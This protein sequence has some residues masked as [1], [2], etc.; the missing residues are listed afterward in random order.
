[1][2]AACTPCRPRWQTARDGDRPRMIYS[3]T[4]LY[5]HVHSHLGGAVNE[6]LRQLFQLLSDTKTRLGV[7]PERSRGW[8]Q[9]QGHLCG[10]GCVPL[11]APRMT[12]GMGPP[13]RPR[14]RPNRHEAHC[15]HGPKYCKHGPKYCKPPHSFHGEF[16]PAPNWHDG[17]A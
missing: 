6:N 15:K 9:H 5:K 14:D 11:A 4:S 13:A 17:H 2:T 7:R 12:A 1:M 8:G 10:R 16:G 3:R